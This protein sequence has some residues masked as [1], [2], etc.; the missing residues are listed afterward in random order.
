MESVRNEGVSMSSDDPQ[1]AIGFSP[2]IP[3]LRIFDEARAREFYCGFLGFSVS[4]E[5][6]FEEDLP[7]YMEVVRDGLTLHLSEHHGDATPGSAVFV[8]L[9]GLHAFHRELQAKVYRYA[10]PEIEKLPWGEW[11][12]VTDPFGNRLRFCE[13]AES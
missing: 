9:R 4:F 2:G 3:I 12:Q 1:S 8:P 5:H 6:R 10:R 13:L 7:L 11:I